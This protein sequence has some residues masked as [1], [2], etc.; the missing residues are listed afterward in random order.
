[1]LCN[2][3]R[4]PVNP[5]EQVYYSYG[6]HSNKFFLE[7]YGFTFLNNRYASYPVNLRMDLEI[8]Q[9]F[10]FN[11]N[12]DAAI[13]AAIRYMVDLEEAKPQYINRGDHIFNL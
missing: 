8:N 7:N 2:N 4:K 13:G 10:M 6:K 1:M 9:E 3:N 11:E 5:G 12:L